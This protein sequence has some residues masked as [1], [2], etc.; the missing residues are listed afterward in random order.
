LYRQ[1]TE[2]KLKLSIQLATAMFLENVKELFWR[3]YLN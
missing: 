1:K 2:L 3:V